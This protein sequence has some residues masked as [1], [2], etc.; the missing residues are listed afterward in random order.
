MIKTDFSNCLTAAVNVR[1]P[2]FDLDPAGLLSCERTPGCEGE[3]STAERG[4][5]H[6]G[7]YGAGHFVKMVHNGIEYGLMQAYSEG[8][9]I[10]KNA[11]SENHLADRC[12]APD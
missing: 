7:P 6:C 10:L 1:I 3:P 12:P 8:F 2:F 5:L 4:Y 11:D 9:D